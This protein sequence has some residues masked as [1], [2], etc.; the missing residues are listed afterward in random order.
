MWPSEAILR[1]AFID[2]YNKNRRSTHVSLD[3]VEPLLSSHMDSEAINAS[4][5]ASRGEFRATL[6]N[7]PFQ[8]R[9]L[10]ILA[11]VEGLTYKEIAQ[12]MDCPIGTVMSRLLRA[13]RRFRV[14][15][16]HRQRGA[17][18]RRSALP[19]PGQG[20]R[21]NSHRMEEVA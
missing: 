1:N 18:T 2:Q 21:D 19:V 14:D 4:L 9:M 3:A 13:R 10:L 15:L 8:H 6:H 5:D 17:A 12:V 7:I 20:E 11:Y 16:Q